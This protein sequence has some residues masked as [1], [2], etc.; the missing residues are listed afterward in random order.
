MK[1][2]VILPALRMKM[3]VRFQSIISV[4]LF[5]NKNYDI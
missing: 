3:K 1:K 5:N 2:Y 4:E